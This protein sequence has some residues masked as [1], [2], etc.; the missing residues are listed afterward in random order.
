LTGTGGGFSLT[1][2]MI[3]AQNI[4]E[5]LNE[6]PFHP[7][8]LHLSDGTAHEVPHPEWA[9]L[10]GNRVFVAERRGKKA[11]DWSVQQLSILHITQ[12]QELNGKAKV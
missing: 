7:F 6:K 10:V 9:W 4:R 11:D 1:R 2:K 5:L 3:T 12:L 8:R